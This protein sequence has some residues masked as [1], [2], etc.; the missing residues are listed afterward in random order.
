MQRLDSDYYT[1]GSDVYEGKDKCWDCTNKGDLIE[2]SDGIERCE[3][4]RYNFELET[5]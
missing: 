4:C 3:D 2:C 5:N 1:A